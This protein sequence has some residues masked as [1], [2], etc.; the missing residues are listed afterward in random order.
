MQLTDQFNRIPIPFPRIRN[1]K[2]PDLLKEWQLAGGDETADVR[3]VAAMIQ[4]IAT[5]PSSP[6]ASWRVRFL[7]FS[8]SLRNRFLQ[9][10]K[11]VF[12]L[13]V[14]VLLLPFLLPVMILTGIAIK[15]DSPGPIL[16]RQERVGKWGET[17][18]C[19]KFR[20]MYVDADDRKN[21][22]MHLNEADG[23]VFK[24]K[25]DPRV[26]RVGRVIRK[27]SIDELPQFFNVIQGNMSM[28]GPRPPVPIEVVQYEF[29][30]FRRLDATPGIT[31]LQ[32][33]KGRSDIS[34]ARWVALDVQYIE[35][36]S[37]RKD[38]WILLMTIPTVISGRG[39]Y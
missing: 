7:V 14:A 20:S 31:G 24:I 33:V 15:L 6:A 27:L 8:W 18:K 30:H 13:L 10:S 5:A 11:R 16:F 38:L 32:Q 37:L 25:K 22:L 12:D 1:R 35:E 9:Y 29:D 23:V 2:K 3:R 26:T 19:L 17:F 34:F 28:V 39:A 21:E 36:Q 4:R